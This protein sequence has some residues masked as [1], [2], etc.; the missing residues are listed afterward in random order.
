VKTCGASAGG[1]IKKK[2]VH[3]LEKLLINLMRNYGASAPGGLFKKSCKF[4]QKINNNFNE[5]LR[6]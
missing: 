4:A 3:L 6:R 5:K 1:I 2:V